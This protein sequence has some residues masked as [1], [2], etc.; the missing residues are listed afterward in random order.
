MNMLIEKKQLKKENWN[1]LLQSLK[2][3][4][5][6]VVIVSDDEPVATILSY[7]D[8]LAVRDV[9]ARARQKRALSIHSEESLATMLASEQA[10]AREWLSPEEDEAWADL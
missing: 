6:E 4:H 5:K 7:D 3:G 2:R 9:L 1:K 8:Y 10:L